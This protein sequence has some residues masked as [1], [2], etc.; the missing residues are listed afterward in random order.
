MYNKWLN[1]HMRYLA[2]LSN[3]ILCKRRHLCTLEIRLIRFINTSSFSH[4]IFSLKGNMCVRL[5]YSGKR[6][7]LR[8]IKQIYFIIHWTYCLGCTLN[9]VSYF[10]S[11]IKG[12]WNLLSKNSF[13]YTLSIIYQNAKC[14]GQKSFF[15]NVFF[16]FF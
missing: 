1:V 9:Y 8:L 15:E 13:E 12:M 4:M 3:Y 7:M 10:E 5:C 14:M 11:I 6:S 2:V 16:L